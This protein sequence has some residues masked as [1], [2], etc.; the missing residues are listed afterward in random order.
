MDV[1]A[2]ILAAGE[3]KAMHSERTRFVHDICGRPMIQW[4]SVAL[5]DAGAKD[6]LYVV[7]YQQDLVRNA[8]GEDKIYIPQETQRGTAHAVLMG[9]NFLESRQGCSLIV[10]GDAPLITS[11][12]IQAIIRYFAKHKPAGI[13]ATAETRTPGSAG[14]VERRKDGSLLALTEPLR[15]EFTQA[16]VREIEA[17]IYCFDTALLLSFMGRMDWQKQ[18]NLRIAAIANAMLNAGHELMSY[19]L[20]YAETMAVNNRVE[21]ETV[22]RHMNRRICEKHM[23]SGVTI[24]NPDACYIEADVVLEKDVH[25]SSGCRL[26]GQSIVGEGSV[27]GPRCSLHNAAIGANCY[28]GGGRFFDCVL[29][30][31]VQIGIN[32]NLHDGVE[33]AQATRIRDNVELCRCKIG[34]M[35]EIDS[36]S[37]IRSCEIGDSCFIGRGVITVDPLIMSDAGVAIT[38]ESEAYSRIGSGTEIGALSRLFRPF[39]I[40]EKT[41]ILPG[42]VIRS[43]KRSLLP[44]GKK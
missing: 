29:H 43:G 19:K 22:R 11:Q 36:Q 15:E 12:S 3:D 37:F 27:L 23:L 5:S 40:E 9:S 38:E 16:N 35:T 28:L 14:G 30:D 34:K 21:L 4:I 31:K 10:P 6:Q 42:S 24:E 8:L 26:S 25:V 39:I 33:I 18:D 13:I 41:D 17:G 32:A 7:G 2:L 1:C 44:W 20:P